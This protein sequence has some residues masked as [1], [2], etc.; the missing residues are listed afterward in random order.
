MRPIKF[1]G[2]L[3]RH[4]RKTLKMLERLR[5]QTGQKTPLAQ[6]ADTLKE[7]AELQQLKPGFFPRG[8]YKGG[9]A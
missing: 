1:K 6:L 8:H 4:G 3:N 5:I 7:R 9:L 2:H